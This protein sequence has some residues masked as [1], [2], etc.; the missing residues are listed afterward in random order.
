MWVGSYV[1]APFEPT[2]AAPCAGPDDLP[3]VSGSLSTSLQLTEPVCCWFLTPVL[4]SPEQVGASLT[5][6]TTIVRVLVPEFTV[7]SLA[8]YVKLSEP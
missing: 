4:E 8:R 5:E 3:Y 1:Q 6:R 7:P 2:E